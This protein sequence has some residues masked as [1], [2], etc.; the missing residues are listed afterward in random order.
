MPTRRRSVVVPAAAIAEGPG[1]LDRSGRGKERL[2]SIGHS[3]T[4]GR[5]HVVSMFVSG[6]KR[7]A[8]PWLSRKIPTRRRRRRMPFAPSSSL[9]SLLLRRHQ[10]PRRTSRR[11]QTAAGGPPVLDGRL[12]VVCYRKIPIYGQAGVEAPPRVLR[13]HPLWRRRWTAPT[14][15]VRRVGIVMTLPPSSIV[16]LIRIGGGPSAQRGPKD[17]QHGFAC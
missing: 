1:R 2:R 6:H 14:R 12:I 10:V 5:R 13:L 17:V 4:I 7:S 15:M 9:R 3:P 11:A 16:I 8:S